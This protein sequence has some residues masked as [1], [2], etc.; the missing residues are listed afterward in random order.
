M[1]SFK[2][3]RRTGKQYEKRISKIRTKGL[4]KTIKITQRR[5]EKYVKSVH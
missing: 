5:V 4:R 2:I 3:A 1:V